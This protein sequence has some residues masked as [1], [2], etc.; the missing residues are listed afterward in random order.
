MEEINHILGFFGHH[1][2]EAFL[3]KRVVEMGSFGNNV[4][5]LADFAVPKHMRELI[6]PVLSRSLACV[7]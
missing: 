5:S 1:Q 2:D 6:S 7:P 4:V 3:E